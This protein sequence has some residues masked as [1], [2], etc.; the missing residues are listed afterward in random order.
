M[1]K[2]SEFTKFSE[3]G[4]NENKLVV[5]ENK[6]D[7]ILAFGFSFCLEVK[8]QSIFKLK[9]KS[10]LTKTTLYVRNIKH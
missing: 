2:E 8:T 3:K 4:V 10:K 9:K 5:I 1:S 7:F 6:F